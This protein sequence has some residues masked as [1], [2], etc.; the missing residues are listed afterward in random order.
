MKYA[1]RLVSLGC[2]IRV[3]LKNEPIFHSGNVYGSKKTIASAANQSTPSVKPPIHASRFV[4]ENVK[5]PRLAINETAIYGNTVI[6]SN[7][8][9]A[10]PII[11]S[12]EQYSPKNS[13]QTIPNTNPLAIQKESELLDL[14]LSAGLC[15]E[16][17]F[18]E[19]RLVTTTTFYLVDLQFRLTGRFLP[20]KSGKSSSMAGVLRF[21]SNCND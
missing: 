21:R 16:L 8:M 12:G 14:E 10:S 3:V 4:S 6:R 15:E 13:P 18:I 2:S 17:L 9:K 1:S 19:S 20:A 11:F 5:R 7:P